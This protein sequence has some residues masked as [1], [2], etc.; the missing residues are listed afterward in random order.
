MQSL[1]MVGA[2]LAFSVM[3]AV[4]KH[5]SAWHSAFEI[6]FFRGLV[7][8][9]LM[10][11][12]IFA[13]GRSVRTSRPGLHATRSLIGTTAMTCWFSTFS[14]LPL[15]T[16]VTLN[17]TSPLFIAIAVA[18]ASWWHGRTAPMRGWLY[19]AIGASFVG[20]L[21]I[22]RP[23]I[24]HDQAGVLMVGLFSGML[25]AVVYLQVRTLSRLGEP[26]WVVVFWFAVTNIVFGAIAATVTTGWH[27]LEWRN[28][29]PLLLIGALASAG[30]MMMTRAFGRGR[31]LLTANLQ[32]LGVIFATVIGWMVFDDRFEWI[33]FAGILLIVVSGAVATRISSA[34]SA[35]VATRERPAPA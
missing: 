13:S 6:V 27:P 3:G 4:I 25:A 24:E 15:A 32:Y 16:S 28:V 2:A 7:S 20:V 18:A 10:G 11:A 19:L 8:A 21:M 5:V 22:L 9:L 12:W 26:D 23:A 31:T 29:G 1:W 33:E 17:Y 14:V 34:G 35:A 30:Q